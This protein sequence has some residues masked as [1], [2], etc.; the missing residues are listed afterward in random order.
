MMKVN[1]NITTNKVQVH[2]GSN[3][4]PPNSIPR[5]C[6]NGNTAIWM[7]LHSKQMSTHHQKTVI[8]K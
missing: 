6:G 5:A 1:S 7:D 4:L 3:L 8:W 2:G